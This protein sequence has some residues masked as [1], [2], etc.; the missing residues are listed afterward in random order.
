MKYV[1]V[2]WQINFRLNFF[3]ALVIGYTFFV[4]AFIYGSMHLFLLSGIT[5][6]LLMQ[7]FNK[8]K[9]GGLH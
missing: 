2:A 7:A 9:T 8:F 3:R 6:L 5:C 1:A 4:M